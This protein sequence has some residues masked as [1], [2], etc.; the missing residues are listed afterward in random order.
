MTTSQFDPMHPTNTPAS[1]TNPFWLCLWACVLAVGWLTPRHRF[2]WG[3]VHADTW[4][5]IVS[6]VASLAVI[7]LY[8]KPMVWHRITLLAALVLCI[9]WLQV[10]AGVVPVTGVA[11]ISTAY[12]LGLLLALLTGAHWERFK[13]GQLADGLFLAIGIAAIIS[14]GIQLQQWLQLGPALAKAGGGLA[15][16]DANLGQ[17]NQL[18]TLLLWG[19]L[20][21]AWGCIRGYMKPAVAIFMALYLL[22]GVALTA[23][24][25]AWLAVGLLLCATWWW[26]NLW[27]NPRTPWVAMGLGVYF[28]VCNVV[29]VWLPTVLQLNFV[30]P[31]V[32]SGGSAQQRVLAWAV[33][34]DAAWHKPLLGYGWNQGAVAQMAWTAAHPAVDGVF[35]FAHNLFL[36][37]VIW[38]GIPVGLVISVCLLRWFWLRLRAVQSAENAILV[39]FLL[40]VANHAMLE[41]PLYYA[42]FL[43]PV[44]MV[45]GVLNVRL[46]APAVL[47]MGIWF[48]RALWLAAVVLLGLVIR[49][50]RRIEP[51]YQNLSFNP[52]LSALRVISNA[53]PDVLLLTQWRDYIEFARSQPKAGANEAALEK[54]RNITALFPST[55]F[56]YKLALA[57]A[58]NNQPDEARIWLIRMCKVV[59]ADQCLKAQRFWANE[60]LKHP[61]VAAIAW[62]VAASSRK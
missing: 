42:Y 14:V 4:I 33:F 54:M 26:R 62:P 3:T 7:F 44:G 25:T 15:R 31:E 61:E 8:R 46:G 19:I 39:L 13:P 6:S 12:V 58:L 43:L 10:A 9:P 21:A 28:V 48:A 5:A 23:S 17:P 49:D 38:C 29:V 55:L 27:T 34:A 22:M 60:A 37:L 16:P 1:A 41:F 35:S 40:V 30:A 32:L 45:M 18:A 57:L 53:P 11:W 51:S 2:P 52:A 47:S 56:N 24:R 50:Y 20:A 59:S 36:D